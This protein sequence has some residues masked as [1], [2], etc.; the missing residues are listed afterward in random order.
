MLPI[1]G[2]EISCNDTFL[3]IQSA[4]P[5]RVLGSAVVGGDLWRARHILNMHVPKTY[6]NPHPEEDLFALARR[7]GI[8]EPFVGLM[9]AA[10]LR[11]KEVVVEQAGGLSVVAIITIGLG[12]LTSVG[13]SLPALWA[14]GTINTILLLDAHLER[15]AQV[16]ALVTA[17]E[18]KT[19]A[20]FE[21]GLLTPEGYPAT[22]TSTDAIVVACTGRGRF[23]RYA[24]PVT[25][26]GW[27]IGR[28]VRRGIVQGVRKLKSQASM[29]KEV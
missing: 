15:S 22:G 27:L 8:E 3:H 17:T 11:D 12:N 19:L 21:E 4:E 20:L 16:G 28:A 2:V 13:R 29:A 24:G 14:L 9:T 25:M 7:I 1:D 18:A 5:L 26:V 23:L 10:C 6:T